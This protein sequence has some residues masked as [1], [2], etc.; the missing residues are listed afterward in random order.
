MVDIAT[1]GLAVRSDQ[2]ERGSAALDKLTGAAEKAE[3]AATRMG[4][5][6]AAAA[7]RLVAANDNA[8]AATIRLAR[9]LERIGDI[10]QR[11]NAILGLFGIALPI[12][13][14]IAALTR[15]ADTW[16]DISARVGVAIGDMDAAPDVMERIGQTA[17]M[18]Y[19]PLALTAEGFIRNSAVLKELGKT[20]QEQLDYQEALNNALVMSGARGQAAQLVQDSLNRSMAM[21]AMRG[22][23]L[24]N[25]LNYGG[26]VAEALARHFNTTT[27]GLMALA[28]EGKITSEVIFEVL[29]SRMEEFR[30]G[31]ESMPATIGDAFTIMG[32]KLLEFVGKF[33]KARGI[34]ETFAQAI[35][36]MGDNIEA[37]VITA[38]LSVAVFAG[39][40]AGPLVK[41]HIS[42]TIETLKHLKAIADGSAVMLGGKVAAEQ[43][44]AAVLNAAQADRAAAAAKVADI[45][46]GIRQLQQNFAIAKSQHAAAAERAKAIKGILDESLATKGLT[47]ALADRVQAGKALIATRK[48]IAASERE[49]ATAMAGTNAA[50]IADIKLTIEQ[51]QQT[52]ALATAQRVEAAARVQ[53]FQSIIYES[54]AVKAITAAEADRQRAARAMLATKS[55]LIA[56]EKEHTAAIATLN[57]LTKAQNVAESQHAVAVAR[58]TLAMRA[59]DAAVRMLTASMKALNTVMAFLG[60]PAGLAITAMGALF[61]F[62]DSTIKIGETSIH[63]GK[64]MEAVWVSVKELIGLVVGQITTLFK[65]L[66]SGVKLDFSAVDAALRAFEKEREEAAFRVQVAWKAAT[67]SME[68]QEQVASHTAQVFAGFDDALKA[69]REQVPELKKLAD[70]QAAVEVAANHYKK[71]LKALEGQYDTNLIKE[72]EYRRK[73]DE[74]VEA[75]RRAVNEASGFADVLRELE[76]KERDVKFG[77]MDRRTAA[78]AKLHHEYAEMEKTIIR[79]GQIEGKTQEE[80]AA[81]V[82]RNT[83]TMNQAIAN[84]LRGIDSK[85]SKE[86]EKSYERAIRQMREAT[87]AAEQEAKVIGLSEFAKE[88]HMGVQKLL[89]AAQKEAADIDRMSAAER[90]VALAKMSEE[91]RAAI[92]LGREFA[93]AQD[94]INASSERLT[95]ALAKVRDQMIGDASAYAK[96]T[97]A[98][99]QLSEAHDLARG[100]FTGFFEDIRSG[101]RQGESVWESFANAATRALDRIAQRML[102][103]A[104]MAVFDQ[105][106][107]PMFRGVMGGLG[108]STAG[109]GLGAGNVLSTRYATG[110]A[111]HAGNV[112]PFANGAAFTNSIVNRPTL[113][114]MARG[115]GLMGESGPEAVVPLTRLP[116][117]RLGVDASDAG[118]GSVNI[119]YSPNIDARGADQAA[120]SRIEKVIARDKAEFEA[121]VKQIVGNRTNARW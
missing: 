6:A 45:E 26:K 77:A 62:R 109:M 13:G 21:G 38:A 3:R 32:N 44:A 92:E 39:Q 86:R 20:T 103:M 61:L 68:E 33:D 71:A 18:T 89:T 64:T 43:R 107:G 60:G 116:N 12:T 97:S 24:N 72:E 55:A 115:M 25:V 100:T 40:I 52:F 15:F 99:R 93:N 118:G 78:I 22:V 114:P 79:T 14:A 82:A 84:A 119:T 70:Q 111:F 4:T 53:N 95:P 49:L 57:A 8:T 88:R 16:S 106:I 48:A 41:A 10:A 94:L 104:A 67:A 113:F 65:V 98:A 56:S 35:I 63:V 36:T 1:L 101:L 73:K 117:G 9:S 81:T 90:A 11:V 74:L 34:S 87:V 66:T 7:N 69:L 105:F 47:A 76:K 2:V 54:G 28:R 27:G 96:A 29:T 59:K 102:E 50:K 110:A 17:R 80:I 31:A 85:G 5:G 112:V 51:L 58:T 75:Y 120:V 108:T 91:Q 121:R 30:Q 83:A 42:A 19:S 23:E 37:A 46:V